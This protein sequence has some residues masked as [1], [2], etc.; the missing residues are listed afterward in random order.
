MRYLPIYR[1]P[2]GG[3]DAVLREQSMLLLRRRN[4]FFADT[5]ANPLFIDSR[6]T[7]IVVF[8]ETYAART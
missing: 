5:V 2:F 3:P 7:E 6:K 1:K 8:G 4:R